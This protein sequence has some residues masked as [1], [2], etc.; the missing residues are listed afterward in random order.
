MFGDG[1]WPL[2][3]LSAVALVVGVR[4]GA[5]KLRSRTRGEAARADREADRADR[6]AARADRRGDRLNALLDSTDDGVMR[7]RS[8]MAIR[9][10]SPV[11]AEILARS[12]ESLRNLPLIQATVDHRLEAIA[13]RA[14]NGES[15]RGEIDLRDARPGRSDE[16]RFVQVTAAPDGDSGA[17]IILRDLTEVRRL[18]Q[19]RTEFVDNLSHELRT[20]LATIRLLAESIATAASRGDNSGTKDRADQIEVEVLHLVQMA[21][22]MLDLATLEAGEIPLRIASVDMRA[23]AEEVASRFQPVAA[24]HG[25][26]I[27][28]VP[29]GEGPWQVQGDRDR[30]RQALANLVHNAVKYSRE[31]GEV[32]ISLNA[33]GGEQL[34]VAVADRGI[35]IDPRHLPRIFERFYTVERIAGEEATIGGGGTGLGLAIARH[36]VLRHGGDIDVTSTIGVGTTFTVTLPKTGP[37]A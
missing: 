16:P 32:T 24:R 12:L 4:L 36:A 20:P 31:R 26:R 14:V 5:G 28:I 15:V 6:A 30:L 2:F 37:R 13:R 23:L 25:G 11:A 1:S 29:Q 34:K 7:V 8:D 19:I 35:G 18:R 17:W 33:L 22:E 10:A 27:T 21:D 3:L 9:E